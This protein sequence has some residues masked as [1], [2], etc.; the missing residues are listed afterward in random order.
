M[1]WRAGVV[2]VAFPA[3]TLT[4]LPWFAGTSFYEADPVVGILSFAPMNAACDEISTG[5]FLSTIS[6]TTFW[7]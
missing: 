5:T 6:A 3:C 4:C 1:N 7:A 2:R